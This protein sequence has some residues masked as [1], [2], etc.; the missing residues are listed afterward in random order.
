MHQ[1]RTSSDQQRNADLSSSAVSSS[2]PKATKADQLVLNFLSKTAQVIVQSRLTD[3]SRLARH[4]DGPSFNTLDSVCPV[5]N[6]DVQGTVDTGAYPTSDPAYPY[7]DAAAVDN[8]SRASRD[9]HSARSS[10]TQPN[11]LPSKPRKPNKWFN[12]EMDDVEP[13]REE[14]RF[15]K[16]HSTG[17]V[18]SHPLT[19]QIYLDIGDLPPS[20]NLLLKNKA[21]QKRLRIGK[22]FLTGTDTAGRTIRKTKIILESWQLSVSRNAPANPP[23]LPVVYKKSIVFFRS[24]YSMLRLMPAYNL[25]RK[26]R[27]IKNTPFAIMYRIS[28]TRTVFFDDVGLDVLHVN[29]D[30]RKGLVEHTFSG[31]ETP[32]GV[33]SLHVTYRAECEFSLGNIEHILGDQY[34]DIEE[35]FFSTP[36]EFNPHHEN[37]SLASNSHGSSGRTPASIGD[38]NT[39]DRMYTQSA[40]KVSISNQPLHY[41]PFTHTPYYGSLDSGTSSR[42]SH[43]KRRDT[44]SS[45]L[46]SQIDDTQHSHVSSAH[47]ELHATR[48][49]SRLSISGERK[50]Y[51]VF[52]PPYEISALRNQKRLHSAFLPDEP[53]PFLINNTF[54][55]TLDS[56]SRLLPSTASPPF[57]ITKQKP[58]FHTP[59]AFREVQLNQQGFPT[60]SLDS[61]QTPQQGQSNLELIRRPSFTLPFVPPNRLDSG[62]LQS[63]APPP[64]LIFSP[65][66][67]LV[68][69]VLRSYKLSPPP[70]MLFNSADMPS[71]DNLS[72]LL[73]RNSINNPLFS[74]TSTNSIGDNVLV[75]SNSN[76]KYGL[77]GDVHMS[78]SSILQQNNTQVSVAARRARSKNALDHFKM[79]KELNASF[80]DSIL[81]LS[82]V[83][84][85]PEM[86]ASLQNP[87]K[88][89]THVLPSDCSDTCS[90]IKNA[91]AL[92]TS[93]L[94]TPHQSKAH[95]CQDKPFNSSP[96]KEESEDNF[97]KF[98]KTDQDIPPQKEFF[99]LD[100]PFSLSLDPVRSPQKEKIGFSYGQNPD[101]LKEPESH[102]ALFQQS[103]LKDI[104]D[105]QPYIR[106][107]AVDFVDKPSVQMTSSL[108]EPFSG[109]STTNS[110]F[111]QTPLF[112]SDGAAPLSAT[113]S[114][115]QVQNNSSFSTFRPSSQLTPFIQK[116]AP[117]S[118]AFVPVVSGVDAPSSSEPL[119]LLSRQVSI[120]PSFRFSPF[121]NRQV[122]IISHQQKSSS[123]AVDIVPT[124][125]HVRAS[126]DSNDTTKHPTRLESRA[127][128]SLNFST[129]VD[130]PFRLSLPSDIA[131]FRYHHYAEHTQ[132]AESSI[133]PQ[134]ST[135]KD[136]KQETQIHSD[137]I[138]SP[139]EVHTQSEHHPHRLYWQRLRSAG[140][141]RKPSEHLDEE[142]DL[143]FNMS[144]LDVSDDHLQ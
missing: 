85:N 89:I 66:S 23:D 137:T 70:M 30:M 78:S 104:G 40:K 112:M 52:T 44:G 51:V 10:S 71:S 53:P 72:E 54:T 28:T 35:G 34:G 105:K 97:L 134:S 8:P 114:I 48:S 13:I 7:M 16:L 33:I 3:V 140:L 86:G 14:M 64:P 43:D 121:K 135:A 129:S 18:Q 20:H 58:T 41:Q 120:D 90:P 113:S 108:R 12:L 75:R 65:S 55:E 93:G 110:I 1:H 59:C 22:E 46:N 109:T 119:S 127:S 122:P 133:V 77:I 91:A 115:S 4:A 96:I 100:R 136:T 5:N 126:H 141:G 94:D 62:S 131:P 118:D 42:F 130:H 39:V 87:C 98:S 123:L 116:A 95:F 45:N 102:I 49:N 56:A 73:R 61:K 107:T 57:D 74:N 138:T 99:N 24:L 143:V 79:M 82:A 26:L 63:F 81:P 103:F 25:C 32:L 128:T 27:S 2:S 67:Q 50:K 11:S 37:D 132:Q 17:G 101:S 124:S 80:T 92:P 111:Q 6:A 76:L 47:E 15:W 139:D 83:N 84:H 9:S 21:S 142:D 29:N 60:Q 68:H 88:D 19:I 144:E 117:T 38:P 69:P 125:R 106:A 31:I 36:S